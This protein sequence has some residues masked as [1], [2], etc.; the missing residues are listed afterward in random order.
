MMLK[1]RRAH[2]VLSTELRHFRASPSLL[3]DGHDLTVWVLWFFS[4][5]ISCV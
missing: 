5:R 3:N 4:C 1:A 2:A